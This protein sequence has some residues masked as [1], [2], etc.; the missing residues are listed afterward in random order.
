VLDLPP[1]AVLAEQSCQLDRV[2]GSGSVLV[3]AHVMAPSCRDL[4]RPASGVITCHRWRGRRVTA[5]S[6]DLTYPAG[7][8]SRLRIRRVT[9]QGLCTSPGL[10]GASSAF[11][12][13]GAP[14]GL[15]LARARVPDYPPRCYRQMCTCKCCRTVAGDRSA[16]RGRWN[17]IWRTTARALGLRLAARWKSQHSNTSGNCVDMA[18]PTAGGDA[19]PQLPDSRRAAVPSWCQGRRC[20]P[21][22][23]IGSAADGARINR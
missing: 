18:G 12:V 5:H 3:L 22:S 15:T 16:G 4:I 1:V 14:T 6:A 17:W 13:R 11:P 7:R 10:R 21:A 8:P 19:G 2:G 20:R 23:T 9:S